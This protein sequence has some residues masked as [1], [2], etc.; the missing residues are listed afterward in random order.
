MLLYGDS[1][2]TGEPTLEIF[3]KPL[4]TGEET[5]AVARDS[6][7]RVLTGWGLARLVDMASLC[8]S[9]V[10]ARLADSDAA[11]V[12]LFVYRRQHEITL[13]I[14]CCGGDD[15]FHHLLTGPGK[16]SRGMALID[17]MVPLW[18]IRPLGEG[19]AVWFELR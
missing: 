5:G 1:P 4:P 3:R 15:R 16:K 9:E 7:E 13:E 17:D 10:A 14:H 19:E 11:T 6:L 2:P 8:V 18:G 12:E